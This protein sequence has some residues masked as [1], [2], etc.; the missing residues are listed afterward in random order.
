MH[1]SRQDTHHSCLPSPALTYI[2]KVRV[3]D[4]RPKATSNSRVHASLSP[5]Q[6]PLSCAESLHGPP[7]TLFMCSSR[8][9]SLG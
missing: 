9:V 7:Q 2:T 5:C 3:D 1:N 8:S 6:R 4:P